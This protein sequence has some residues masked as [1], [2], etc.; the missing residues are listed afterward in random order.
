MPPGPCAATSAAPKAI[1]NGLG[2]CT[3]SAPLPQRPPQACNAVQRAMP[4]SVMAT[5]DCV[6]Q[7]SSPAMRAVTS[8]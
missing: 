7:R 4:S 6:P 1:M 2:M 5:M 8:T 3:S